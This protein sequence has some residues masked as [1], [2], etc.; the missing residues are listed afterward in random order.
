MLKY[1]EQVYVPDLTFIP[2]LPTA[3]RTK[4][5]SRDQTS[6]RN[7]Q[8]DT[9]STKKSRTGR[10]IL[11]SKLENHQN[12][13]SKICRGCILCF[14]LSFLN[15]TWIHELKFTDYTVKSCK[16]SVKSKVFFLIFAK[17]LEMFLQH[18]HLTRFL[19]LRH[20]QQCRPATQGHQVAGQEAPSAVAEPT[21]ELGLQL[22]MM[23]TDLL[24]A[25]ILVKNIAREH[26]WYFFI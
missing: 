4:V 18:L 5:R 20:R 2:N 19:C 16:I 24:A 6:Q 23:R 25:E 15:F 17:V 1:V 22:Q 14:Y 26:I 7:P 13:L 12:L 9:K 8:K 11:T 10:P 3:E 21:E